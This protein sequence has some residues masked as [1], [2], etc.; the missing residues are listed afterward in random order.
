MFLLCS[1]VLFCLKICHVPKRGHT[2]EK[3]INKNKTIHGWE[4][5]T[6]QCHHRFNTTS[7]FYRLLSPRGVSG[8]WWGTEKH[9]RMLWMWWIKNSW[10][11]GGNRRYLA[12][13]LAWLSWSKLPHH[14]KHFYTL[15]WQ[16]FE[17]KHKFLEPGANVLGLCDR[18]EPYIIRLT[19]QNH[20]TE[21]WRN[22]K[23]F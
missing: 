15:P 18:G 3:T 10:M 6:K 13:T 2:R 9:L 8:M 11:R 21:R 1:T 22:L 7:V 19:Q 14:Y 12:S 5:Q 16:S 17:S 4:I 20:H 23:G